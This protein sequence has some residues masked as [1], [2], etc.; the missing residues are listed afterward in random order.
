MIINAVVSHTTAAR[1]S[2]KPVAC[3]QATSRTAASYSATP[4]TV[5]PFQ[6]LPA[7]GLDSILLCLPCSSSSSCCTGRSTSSATSLHW[8][9]CLS[10]CLR[11]W[12]CEMACAILHWFSSCTCCSN[13]RSCRP[14]DTVRHRLCM[15]RGVSVLDSRS[16]GHTC[17]VLVQGWSGVSGDRGHAAGLLLLT[18]LLLLL[19]RLAACQ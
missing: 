4:G 1:A 11:P 12:I 19:Q 8:W 5:L 2:R 3:H 16:V 18:L 15:L 6:A 14:S 9:C 17:R 13:S 7:A 10:L